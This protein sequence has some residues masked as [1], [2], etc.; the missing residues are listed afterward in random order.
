ML[1]PG[2]CIS[3]KLSS[4]M[5]VGQHKQ[6]KAKIRCGCFESGD[7]TGVRCVYVSQSE[8]TIVVTMHQMLDFNE[9]DLLV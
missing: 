3:F 6:E 4:D 9:S 7:H 5:N 1:K 8:C 2:H